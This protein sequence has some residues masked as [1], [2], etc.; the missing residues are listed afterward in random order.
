MEN[1]HTYGIETLNALHSKYKSELDNLQGLEPYK[2]E[3]IGLLI[4]LNHGVG[5]G[6][7]PEQIRKIDESVCW[8]WDNWDENI[9][10]TYYSGEKPK[11][12]T[13]DFINQWVENEDFEADGFDIEFL[14]TL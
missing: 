7:I 5:I 12:P 8:A 1:K 14:K 10:S 11:F 3:V 4:S 6:I 13:E 9:V 2:Q